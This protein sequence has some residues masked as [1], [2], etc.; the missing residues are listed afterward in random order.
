MGW[1][2]RTFL[3]EIWRWVMIFLV[4]GLIV[5]IID[6]WAH[7]GG[8][9]GGWLAARVLDPLKAESP[10]H[11]LVGLVCLA[12]MAASIIASVVLGIPLFLRG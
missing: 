12:L 1:P 3:A 6:N 11:M 7:L 4:I 2:P 10:I 8:Y 5:P 9:A